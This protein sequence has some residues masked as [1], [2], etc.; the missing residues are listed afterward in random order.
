MLA[1]AIGLLQRLLA[2]AEDGDR[3]GTVIEV[4]ALLALARHRAGEDAEALDAL[5]RTLVLA[6]PEGYVRVLPAS[7]SGRGSAADAEQGHGRRGGGGA[8]RS[9]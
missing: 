5:E 4:L 3:V 2:S 1:D 7:G 6:E 9:A 8:V